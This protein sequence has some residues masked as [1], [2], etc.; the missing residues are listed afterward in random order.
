MIRAAAEETTWRILGTARHFFLSFE[1][2]ACSCPIGILCRHDV[3]PRYTSYCAC[4]ITNTAAVGTFSSYQT[5]LAGRRPWSLAKT[6]SQQIIAST[7]PANISQTGC[8]FAAPMKPVPTSLPPA[9]ALLS[10]ASVRSESLMPSRCL[11]SC[12]TFVWALDF[13]YIQL[14][15]EMRCRGVLGE[16][17]ISPL[18]KKDATVYHGIVSLMPHKPHCI[19]PLSVY[20]VIDK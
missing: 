17:K 16:T 10:S 5:R 12:K 3:L 9:L 13:K 7:K 15:I 4:Y 14:Y 6:L 1:L 11:T 19:F 8:G 20:G 2:D 18:S